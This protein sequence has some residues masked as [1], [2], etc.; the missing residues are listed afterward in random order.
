[1]NSLQRLSIYWD[2]DPVDVGQEAAS[3]L[4]GQEMGKGALGKETWG[5]W[6]FPK[7]QKSPPRFIRLIP[8]RPGS[9]NTQ[10][11]ERGRPGQMTAANSQGP[12][13]CP[14]RICVCAST[15]TVDFSLL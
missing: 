1:M 9:T 5:S 10:A 14:D 13:L 3:M 15:H 11:C 12:C 8:T 4:T 6:L 7:S 2:G